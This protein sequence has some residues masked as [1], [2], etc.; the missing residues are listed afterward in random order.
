MADEHEPRFLTETG[1]AARVAVI[2]EE[3]LATVGLRLVRVKILG[4]ATQTV[5][6]MAERPD[7]TMSVED[8]EEASKAISPA[9]DVEDPVPGMYNL[10]VSSPGIDR[11]L[12]RPSDFERWAGHEAK[13]ELR[14]PLEGRKRFR[15]I[16][17]GLDG[18][19]ALIE[20]P[21]QD[22][23][24]VVA[25]LA[26]DDIGE[27]RLVLTDDLIRESL[28]RAKRAEDDTD[29]GEDSGEPPA[30]AAPAPEA[31]P[32]SWTKSTSRPAKP[33]RGPGRF[34]RSKETNLSEE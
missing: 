26:L 29:A 10:E 12:V 7:G 14:N 15:G 3:A 17:R 13:I 33:V 22:G 28:R 2:A 1:L 6:I 21:E 34:T 8:C 31:P 25:S 19:A 23:E 18:E 9:L 30:E 32:K 24:E 27:A 16:I 11:P 4:G 20:L 5:Q